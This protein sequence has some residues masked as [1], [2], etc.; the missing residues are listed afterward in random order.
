MGIE[1]AGTVTIKGLGEVRRIGFGAMRIIGDGA[2]GEPE[3]LDAAHAVVRRAVELGVDFIDTAD[4]YGPEVSERILA[5]TLHPYPAGL[6]IGTKAGQARPGPGTWV[7]LGRAKYLRQQVELSLRRL[8]VDALDLFQLHR[9][10]P[11]VELAEQFGVM[12]ELQSEGKVRALGLSEVSLKQIQEAEKHFTVAS[13]QNRYNV[14]DRRSEG[15]LDYCTANGIAFLP[16]A[17]LDAGR[18]AEKGGPVDAA[19]ERLGATHSQVA[20]AWLLH[21]SPMMLPIPGTSSLAH[22]EANIAAADL[23]LD[24]DALTELD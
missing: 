24:G 7:P 22:L 12:A 21:R 10:D 6:R 8:K 11:K 15:V 19:A 9:I 5:D 18:L 1:N 20:L 2:W 17:P 16:W 14:S 23:E 13:V 4:S 3:D